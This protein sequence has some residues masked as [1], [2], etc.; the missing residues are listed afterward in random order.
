[1]ITKN[2][3]SIQVKMISPLMF[4]VNGESLLLDNMLWDAIMLEDKTSTQTIFCCRLS[5][6]VFQNLLI[7]FR[8]YDSFDHDKI[9]SSKRTETSPQH[10]TPTSMF[11]SGDGV[12]WAEHL[13]LLTPNIGNISMAKELYFCLIWPKDTFLV[14]IIFLQVVLQTSV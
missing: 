4:M 7:V 11:H 8:F 13:S 2:K 12:L 3:K 6:V 14:C 9:P 1:M 10:Y 5:E